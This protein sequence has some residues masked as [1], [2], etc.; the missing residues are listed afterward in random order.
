MVARN[1][2]WRRGWTGHLD[3]AYY[4]EFYDQLDDIFSKLVSEE[5][6]WGP[7]WW[8]K[9]LPTEKQ[10]PQDLLNRYGLDDYN[11]AVEASAVLARE[12]QL[13]SLTELLEDKSGE[14]YHDLMRVLNLLSS[15]K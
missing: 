11:A 12:A 4:D 6:P 1:S 8:F 14:T 9:G 7:D 15:Y 10:I 3:N 5:D 2:F 13:L